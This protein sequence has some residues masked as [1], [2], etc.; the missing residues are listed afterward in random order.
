MQQA[1]SLH[2]ARSARCAP[3]VRPAARRS[4]RR[5]AV[6][7]PTTQS[8]WLNDLQYHSEKWGAIESEEQFLGTLKALVDA[9]LCPPQLYPAWADFYSNYRN[10]MIA[11][12]DPDGLRIAAKVQSGIADCVFKQFKEPYTFP[13]VHNRIMEPY[14][15]YQ[16]GQRYVG[17]LI[18]FNAS[19]LG[20]RERFDKI[21]EQIAQGHNVVLLANHQTEADPG[22]FAHM[23]ESVH[24]NLATD[25]FYVAGDRV[26]SD[27]L[28]VPFSMGRNLFCVHS[29]KHINDVPELKKA[30][31]ETNRKTLV[32]G[33]SS[34]S[35][36]EPPLAPGT[37]VCWSEC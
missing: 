10:A 1:K 18:D 29:K 3:G 5:A 19:V 26:V 8:K 11:S 24:P 15:Y 33:C 14:N 7:A 16:F 25:V 13:S 37:A 4:V 17:S 35:M 31:M 23:L 9:K 21:A 2:S 34:K 12:G 6:E 20:F 27:P 28:C 32:R 22:V 36:F 30:K